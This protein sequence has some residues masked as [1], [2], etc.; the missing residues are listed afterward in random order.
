MLIIDIADDALATL[1]AS[2]FPDLFLG[3]KVLL[4]WLMF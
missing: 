2:R 4:N 3:G 1:C